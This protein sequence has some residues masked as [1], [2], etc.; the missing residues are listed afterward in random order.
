[1]NRNDV[2]VIDGGK[3]PGLL[4]ESSEGFAIGRHLVRQNLES[5]LAVEM[6]VLRPIDLAHPTLAEEIQDLVVAQS[7][8]NHAHLAYSRSRLPEPPRVANTCGGP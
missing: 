4:L 7:L 3:G 8:A 1:M 5:D 6:R 2:R